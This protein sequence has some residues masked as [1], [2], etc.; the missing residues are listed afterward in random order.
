MK[1]FCLIITLIFDSTIILYSQTPGYYV[2]YGK[3]D[4]STV[5][6]VIGSAIEINV[7]AAT[8]AIGSGYEDLN[9]DGLVDSITFIHSPLASD[10]N[11]IISRNGGE[12]YFPLDQ[13]DY[14]QHTTPN[15]LS[16]P[17]GYTNQSATDDIH[18]SRNS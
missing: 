14:A 16:D 17:P 3:R 11:Y 13:W 5:N 7:W 9:S 6:V 8:P 2:I 15:P 18:R 12:V 4:G 10:N 1:V